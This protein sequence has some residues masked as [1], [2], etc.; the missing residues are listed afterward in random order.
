[1][2]D[3]EYDAAMDMASTRP[4]RIVCL[5]G[6]AGAL[7][8]YQAILRAIPADSGLAF[9]VVAHR[10][11]GFD[12]LLGS[13]LAKATTMP[14]T[15]IAQGQQVQPNTVVLLPAEQDVT[16]SHGRLML[17]AQEKPHGWPTTITQFLQSMAADAADHP[18]AVILSGLDGDG[19][20]ALAAIKAAGGTTFA[21]ADAEWTD[22][23]RT[24]ID[25][26]HIDFVLRS[27]DIGKAL[28]LL[29]HT[30]LS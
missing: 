4:A 1:M 3:V 18:V 19:S 8:A 5:G 20:A 29:A 11:A 12:H 10:R 17:S 27:E 26:G 28:A 30:P 16:L 6:S 15:A 2:F 23:P 24:A 22:M 9:V 13:I 21:Q 7:S 25:T 14:V